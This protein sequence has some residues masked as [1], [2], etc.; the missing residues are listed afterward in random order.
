MYR[1]PRQFQRACA[2][3]FVA[4]WLLFPLLG[5]LHAGTHAHRLCAEHLALEEVGPEFTVSPSSGPGTEPERTGA[6]EWLGGGSQ[7]VPHASCV[8]TWAGPREAG[9]PARAEFILRSCAPRGPL[10][11]TAWDVLAPPVPLLSLAPKVS[12]PVS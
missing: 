4:L 8:L 6:P 9:L 3:T 1:S 11:R 5:L 7:D 10:G 12:P 2:A